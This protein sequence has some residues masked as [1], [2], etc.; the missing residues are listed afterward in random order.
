MTD[1]PRRAS[2]EAAP[3][4][5]QLRPDATVESAIRQT[6]GGAVEQGLL[7]PSAVEDDPASFL[8]LIGAADVAVDEAERLLADAV[9]G[10]R[11][12]GHSWEAIGQVT[13]VSRQAAQQRFGRSVGEVAA[14]GTPGRKVVSRVHVFNELSVLEREGRAGNRLVSFGVG[15]LVFEEADRP[16]EHLRVAFAT[17]TTLRALEADG[18]QLVG[19]WYPFAYLARP[20]AL[21]H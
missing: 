18:W 2:R 6:I 9:A 13:G 21:D 10:A 17:H 14:T 7:D 20:A 12:A 15:R 5:A 11:R 1:Q 4:P 8:R 3:D 19:R 16:W